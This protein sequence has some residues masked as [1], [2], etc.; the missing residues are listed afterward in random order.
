MILATLFLTKACQTG[1]KAYEKR[2]YYQSVLQ[3]VDK[4]RKNPNNNKARAALVEA[5]PLAIQTIDL[6]IKAPLLLTHHYQLHRFL[7]SPYLAH[8]CCC[9]C[10][11]NFSLHNH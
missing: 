1:K 2:N 3:S 7:P 5:Y 8:P 6:N 4:L 9:S 10:I 11:A